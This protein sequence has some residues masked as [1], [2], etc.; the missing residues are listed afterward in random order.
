MQ[1]NKKCAIII[2]RDNLIRENMINS[3][4][5]P[6]STYQWMQD[7]LKGPVTPED[8]HKFTQTEI[9]LMKSSI[10]QSDSAHKREM[11]EQ[12]KAIDGQN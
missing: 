8:F 11:D 2:I 1:K 3:I 5:S 12:K 7:N 4:D 6:S 10:Q 9:G